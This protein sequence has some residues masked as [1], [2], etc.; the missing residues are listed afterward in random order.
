[1]VIY[2]K[3]AILAVFEIL[4]PKHIGVTALIF[5]GHLTSSVTWLFDSPLAY[6]ICFFRQFFGR[7][8]VSP[9]YMRY[10]RQIDATL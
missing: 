2:N 10:R 9:Q 3:S 1:M 4:S 5:R 8:T 7:C 6:P